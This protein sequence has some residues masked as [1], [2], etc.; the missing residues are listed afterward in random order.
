MTTVI[1]ITIEGEWDFTPEDVFGLD[2][3]PNPITADDVLKVIREQVHDASGLIR[4]WSLD[5]DLG[6]EV[7]VSAPNPAYDPDPDPTL[8]DDQ[9]EPDTR[10]RIVTIGRLSRHSWHRNADQ[11]QDARPEPTDA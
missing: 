1:T 4:D 8:F 2:T 7:A 6:L 9:P 11:D 5:G 3:P 10:P